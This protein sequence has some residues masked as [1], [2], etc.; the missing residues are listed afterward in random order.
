MWIVSAIPFTD[1]KLMKLCYGG[2]YNTSTFTNISRGTQFNIDEILAK[3]YKNRYCV[4]KKRTQTK[5][6]SEILRSL[7]YGIN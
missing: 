1:L 3:L 7:N 6:N 4:K 5:K 2:N